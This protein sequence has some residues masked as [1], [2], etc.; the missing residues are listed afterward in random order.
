MASC[1]VPPR[2]SFRIGQELLHDQGRQ[3]QPPLHPT[4]SHGYGIPGVGLYHLAGE[5][6]KKRYVRLPSYENNRTV[7]RRK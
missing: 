4:G 5:A 7:K 2:F 6:I 3:L 1:D